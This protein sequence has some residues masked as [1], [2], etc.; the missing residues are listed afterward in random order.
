VP[1]DVLSRY[2]R[3]RKGRRQGDRRVLVP[4]RDDICDGCHMKV[5]AQTKMDMRK[6]KPVTCNNCA[7]L[8]Y[9]EE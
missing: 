5:T 8:V 9:L 4:V 3:M 2:E 1:K 6:G 7:L